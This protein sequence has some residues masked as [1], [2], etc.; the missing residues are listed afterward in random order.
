MPKGVER[1][2]PHAGKTVDRLQPQSNRRSQNHTIRAHYQS[3]LRQ[4]LCVAQNSCPLSRCLRDHLHGRVADTNRPLGKAAWTLVLDEEPTQQGRD[5]SFP[6]MRIISGPP[7]ADTV[8]AATVFQQYFPSMRTMECYG[9][10]DSCIVF[11]FDAPWLL[12]I[13]FVH[14]LLLAI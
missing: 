14:S 13:L 12:F 7:V 5:G 11:I 3:R 4:L 10:G 1:S 8:V 9:E 2:D 6:I